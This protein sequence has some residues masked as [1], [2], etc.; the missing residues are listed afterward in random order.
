AQILRTRMLLTSPKDY[1]ILIKAFGKRSWWKQAM[2]AFEEMRDAGHELGAFAYSAIITAMGRDGRW[3]DALHLL[4]ESRDSGVVPDATLYTSAIKACEGQVDRAIALL[5]DM[6]EQDL[7]MDVIAYGVAIGACASGQ[8]W[9]QAVALLQEAKTGRMS[10]SVIS[11]SS[12]LSALR[13]SGNWATALWLMEEM[14]QEGLQPNGFT[15]SALLGVLT[16]SGQWERALLAWQKFRL[17]LMALPWLTALPGRHELALR[18]SLVLAT[19]CVGLYL[20]AFKVKDGPYYST[21]CIL[22]FVAVLVACFKLG[23][24]N[25]QAAKLAAREE[26]MS[27][28]AATKLDLK[29]AMA[30]AVEEATNAASEEVNLAKVAFEVALAVLKRDVKATR[31]AAKTDVMEAKIASKLDVEEARIAAKKDVEEAIVAA[32]D[33]IAAAM[34]ATKMDVEEAKD[35]AKIEIEEAKAEV[36]AAAKIREAKFAAREDNPERRLRRSVSLRGAL[37]PGKKYHYFL[38][39]K[40]EHS[41]LGRQPESLAMAIHDSQMLAGFAGF[42]DV[43]DL[44]TITPEQLAADVR[45]SCAMVVVLH[46]ET[47]VSSWCRFEWKEAESAGIP[48]LCIVDAHHVCRTTVLEQVKQCSSHL[49]VHQ[50]VS[51]IDAYRHDASIQI[52]DWLHEHA[53]QK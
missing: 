1:S 37:P 20:T 5:H 11:Y 6:R 45:M 47:C 8:D 32:S 53:I 49:M 19:L 15:I 28:M 27:A 18:T 7:E 29:A 12:A 46:D 13:E 16:S 21:A 26:V 39:H 3:P 22:A 2:G 48:V 14:Q 33:E 52:T 31:V 40:K 50:W 34:A 38:S 25:V 41:I 10:A 51:Y 17:M 44:K 35:A 36:M 24:E 43:D 30:A 9:K 4:Q 42:F 23:K